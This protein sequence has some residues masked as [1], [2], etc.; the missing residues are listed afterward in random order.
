MTSRIHPVRI[1]FTLPLN[2][3]TRVDRV[4]FSYLVLGEQLAVID[5]GT[6]GNE[7][8]IVSALEALSKSPKDISLV[9]NTHEHPDHIGGNL[10][11]QAAANPIFACHA[12]AVRW[13]EALGVQKKERPI[14]G[15]HSLAGSRGVPIEKKLQ[16]G[17]V[18]D[19]GDG[20]CL[21][22]IWCPGHSPG[23]I[24]I[25]CPK[26]GT[27]IIADAVQPVDGLPLYVDLAQTRESLNKL[28]RLTGVRKMYLAWIEAPY[29]GSEIE[30]VLQAGLNYL[31]RVDRITKEVAYHLPRDLSPAEITQE[32]L[33]RLDL[34][35]PPVMA[36]TIASVMAHL[37]GSSLKMNAKE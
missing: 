16:D 14:Y 20:M 36:M 33:L 4:V 1:P 5:T 28:L 19:L 31:D 7:H 32:V 27:L 26:E 29:T 35:P 8:H 23:S 13:I 11:F 34:D 10:F 15:F 30:N 2:E 22:V 37:E 24:S 21:Q 25:F 9:I 3:T 6:A 17:D 12:A 18:V